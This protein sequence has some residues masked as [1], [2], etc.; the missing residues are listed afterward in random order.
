M[1]E[2]RYAELFRSEARE[3]LGSITRLLLILERDPERAGVLDEL[4][5]SVHTLKGS[6]AA[7]GY[8]AATEL[9]HGLEN[10]LERLRSGSLR[11]DGAVVDLLL[12]GADALERAIHRPADAT[13]AVI[14]DRLSAYAAPAADGGVTAVRSTGSPPAQASDRLRVTVRIDGEAAL[15]AVRAVMVLRAAR[16]LGQVWDIEPEEEGM[17]AG[18]LEG[19]F[20]FAVSADIDA[21]ALEAAVRAVG[22]IESVE[23]EGPNAAAP[24]SAPVRAERPDLGP[25]VRVPQT[26]LDSVVDQMGELMIARDRLRRT[27]APEPGSELE[28]TLDA[29]SKLIDQLRREIMRLRM[30]PV[31]E[32]FDRFPR[33]VRDAARSLGRRV[34][35][36]I[37]G[38]D[39]EV[40]RGLLNEVADLLVHLLRNAVDHGI[41]PPGE[42]I[43]AGKPETGRIR[44]SAAR[45]GS[46]VR[47]EVSDDGRGLQRDRIIATATQRGLVEP[48]DVDLTDA[49]VWSLV[50]M[51][52][53][54]TSEKITEVSGRGVGLDVVRSRAQ[55]LG[56]SLEIRSGG[57]EGASFA[58]RLPLSLT[59]MR[60]LRFRAAG[61][62]YSI[63]LSAVVEVVAVDEDESG[64][65]RL[66]DELLPAVDLPALFSLE[67]RGKSTGEEAVVV[68]EFGNARMG[69]IV[70]ALEGQHQVVVKP[71]DPPRPMLDLFSGA[72]I[73]PDGCPSLIVDPVRLA[74]L[75]GRAIW[76]APP[77]T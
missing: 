69:L 17:L 32:V 71:F 24:T 23:V 52:G 62:L 60:A 8:E 77:T 14:L 25:I 11:A 2:S 35:L 19:P 63:P 61:A 59:L 65:V 4:F 9:T 76:T 50:T 57:G 51:A 64:M 1:D 39:E 45:E 44:L 29:V 22:E 6:S 33:M 66:R 74:A 36:E 58:L 43:A 56:G 70:E 55:I 21:V 73:L 68:V 47:I 20:S 40:D 42:R 67:P 13:S 31:G 28:E 49:E 72:T 41:E 53:F 26:R 16:E 5:R 7:M 30:V 15:P 18:Q 48:S 54:S 10:L 34:E 12:Q 37:S 75:A 3:H 38:R 27:A 46:T